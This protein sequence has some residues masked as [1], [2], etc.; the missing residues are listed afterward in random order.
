[1]LNDWL[2]T[3]RERIALYRA[4]HV[5]HQAKRDREI[6]A[7]IAATSGRPRYL[8]LG[9]SNVESCDLQPAGD[10]LPI[11]AGMSGGTVATFLFA[12]TGRAYVKLCRPAVVV[13]AVGFNDMQRSDAAVFGRDYRA[14]L[15]A[16]AGRSIMAVGISQ[17]DQRA[18]DFN[19]EI[20]RVAEQSGAVMRHLPSVQIGSDSAHYTPDGRDAWSH[21]LAAAIIEYRSRRRENCSR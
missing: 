1:V 17:P 13:V 6:R 15:D 14:L 3:S 19:R 9:D 11:N 7:E 8:V 2:K 16:V 10:L 20:E 4:R 18:G 21:N 12:G 5:A